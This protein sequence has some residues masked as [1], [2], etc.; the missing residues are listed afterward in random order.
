MR[1]ILEIFKETLY[2]LSYP[3]DLITFVNSS[4]LKT[5][6]AYTFRINRH[7]IWSTGTQ[8]L[9]T[10]SSVSSCKQMRRVGQLATGYV[11]LGT[12]VAI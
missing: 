9:N 8:Q 4:H 7:V 1:Q 3:F 12:D 10:R 2:L 6:R 5:I 11:Q